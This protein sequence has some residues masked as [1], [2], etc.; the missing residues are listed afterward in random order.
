MGERLSDA[1]ACKNLV[2]KVME[3]YQMPYITVT[4]TFS[5]CPKH[6]YVNGEHD[7]CPKCDA[8]IGYAG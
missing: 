1:E 2:R 6:G 8:E 7:Y 3:N 4:P 5:V